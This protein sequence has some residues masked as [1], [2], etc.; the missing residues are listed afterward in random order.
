MM[1]DPQQQADSAD[2]LAEQQ[3][4]VVRRYAVQLR[5]MTTAAKTRRVERGDGTRRAYEI[6]NEC[7]MELARLT[8]P[9]RGATDDRDTLPH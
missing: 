9:D 3:E 2:A 7:A 5:E 8:R 4:R 6:L 1:A